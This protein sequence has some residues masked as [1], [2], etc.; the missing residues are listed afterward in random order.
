[1]KETWGLKIFYPVYLIIYKLYFNKCYLQKNK[2][3]TNMYCLCFV[4]KAFSPKEKQFERR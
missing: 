1:M 3:S 2:I 4:K